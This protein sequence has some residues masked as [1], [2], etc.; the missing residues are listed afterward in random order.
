MVLI[1]SSSLNR[2]NHHTNLTSSAALVTRDHFGAFVFVM[3]VMYA[4]CFGEIWL[5]HGETKLLNIT[6]GR[7]AFASVSSSTKGIK[8]KNLFNSAIYV[9]N[10][11]HC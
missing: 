2:A 1:L 6:S 11:S 7:H 5:M 10:V 3:A 9:S 8:L 4:S